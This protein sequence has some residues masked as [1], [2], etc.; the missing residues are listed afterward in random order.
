MPVGS[1][2]S[3]DDRTRRSRCKSKGIHQTIH[4]VKLFLHHQPSNG[5]CSYQNVSDASLIREPNSSGRCKCDRRRDLPFSSIYHLPAICEIQVQ[6]GHALHF[7]LH[8]E[9][10]YLV[11]AENPG[12]NNTSLAGILRRPEPCPFLVS[13]LLGHEPYS[14]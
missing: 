14:S 5:K 7:K 8:H 6:V 4:N 10:N 12:I 11:Q 2:W 3:V 1:E 9:T 13:F